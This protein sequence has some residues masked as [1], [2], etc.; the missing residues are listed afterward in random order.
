MRKPV[1]LILGTTILGSLI[2]LLIFMGFW[3]TMKGPPETKPVS[4]GQPFAQS[5]TNLEPTGHSNLSPE[6]QLILNLVND[7]RAKQFKKLP[8]LK[9]NALL[10][11]VARDYAATMAKEDKLDEDLYEEKLEKLLTAA[12]YNQACTALANQMADRSLQPSAV[13][14]AWEDHI[15]ARA[16]MLEPN[17]DT[18]IGVAKSEKGEIYYLMIYATPKK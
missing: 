13:F 5:V 2:S 10:F 7:L 12:G 4:R 16:M 11:K 1:K 18:G 15:A 8:P 17:E 9:P 6:E 3:F 14:Q